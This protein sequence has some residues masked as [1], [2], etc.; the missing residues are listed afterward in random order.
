MFVRC[1]MSEALN[2]VLAGEV[3]NQRDRAAKHIRRVS[4]QKSRAE[5]WRHRALLLQADLSA[6]R[7][8]IV[9][10]QKR[11]DRQQVMLQ[12]VR[13]RR[14]FFKSLAYNRRKDK[15]VVYDY[16]GPSGPASCGEGVEGGSVGASGAA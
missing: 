14:D 7:R 6:A 3:H 15:S 11:L 16:S 13:D 4:E 5:L 9:T 1:M 8:E 2:V 12:D 10:L